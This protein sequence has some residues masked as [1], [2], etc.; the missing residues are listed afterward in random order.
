G[1]LPAS[2]VDQAEFTASVPEQ[3][4]RTGFARACVAVSAPSALDLLTTATQAGKWND[5]P[6]VVEMQARWLPTGLAVAP[7]DC[8]V[9][10]LDQ[11]GGDGTGG[12]PRGR[13]GA[14]GQRR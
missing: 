9:P 7:A 8:P 11:G 3:G 14:C 1:V 6:V 10:S 2:L 4:N 12:R 13:R 5:R